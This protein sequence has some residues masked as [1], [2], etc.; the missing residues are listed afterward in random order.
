[1]NNFCKIQNSHIYILMYHYV[2]PIKNSKYPEIKG[3]EF[4]KFKNQINDLCKNFNILN[5]EDFIEIINSK[6][7][8]NK[9]SVL[10]TFD[11]GYKDHF[12]FVFPY[13]KKKKISGLFFPPKIALE[14]NFVMNVNKIHYILASEN[15]RTKIINEI[16]ELIYAKT[17]MKLENLIPKNTIFK[18]KLDDKKTTYIKRSLQYFLPKSIRDNVISKL[19]ERIVDENDNFAKKLYINLDEV[20]EMNLNNMKFGYHGATHEW[21]EHMSKN[22]QEK[23]L[24]DSIKYFEKSQI[25]IKYKTLAYP[26]GSYNKDSV[27]VLKKNNIHFALTANYGHVNNKNIKLK[28]ELQRYDGN[29]FRYKI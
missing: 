10:L 18:Q 1:M 4:N 9:P 12:N 27:D 24:I 25:D 21:W 23:D 8:P 3:M 11:D 28:Y 20:K 5:M 16:N 15:N 26:Y 2:R 29:Q 6:K 22:D 13:L 19:F 14:N 7:I 17:K